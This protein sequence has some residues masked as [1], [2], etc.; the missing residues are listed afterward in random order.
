LKEGKPMMKCEYCGKKIGIL[1]VRYTWLDKANKRAMHDKC[2][3]KYKKE[4]TDEEK[5]EIIE[6]I[7]EEKQVQE[8]E[9]KP[10][11]KMLKSK[12][13]GAV[14]LIITSYFII[15]YFYSRFAIG[16]QITMENAILNSILYGFSLLIGIELISVKKEGI[17]N[18]LLLICGIFLIVIYA[19]WLITMAFAV[20]LW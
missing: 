17:Y 15:S 1:A 2:Y 10:L 18:K 20:S 12:I 9:T 7:D 6:Q 4:Q 5:P 14:L 8:E 19:I 3:E 16:T 13:I 11:E